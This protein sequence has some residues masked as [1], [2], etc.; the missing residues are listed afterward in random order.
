M[1]IDINHAR[2]FILENEKDGAR[3]LERLRR[4]EQMG[5]KNTSRKKR[6]PILRRLPG[7]K[8]SCAR[9]IQEEE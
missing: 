5:N 9:G 8:I 7:R 4:L 6:V 2:G 1:E 3:V